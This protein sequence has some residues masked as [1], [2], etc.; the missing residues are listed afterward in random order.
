MKNILIALLF[1]FTT[2]VSLAQNSVNYQ[3][4]ECKDKIPLGLIESS[5]SK[6]KKDL[7]KLKELEQSRKER[8]L[9]SKFSLESHFVLDKLLQSGAVLFNDE[10]SNYLNQIAQKVLVNDSEELKSKVRVY[11][12]RSPYV[13]AFATE[14]GDIF[15]TLGLL[16][17]LQNEGQL[18]F[19]LAH[20]VSHVQ[21]KHSIKS[22]LETAKID[23]HFS[24]RSA[25][26]TSTE[27]KKLLRK[28]LYSKELE[29]E[30]DSLAVSRYL[31]AGYDKA[32]IMAVFEVLKK[33]EQPF[34]NKLFD[35]S[36]L[37]A[38]S[39]KIPKKY[40]DFEVTKLSK[41]DEFEEDN[42]S[43]HPNIG[44]RKE[45]VAKLLNRNM[46]ILQ[47]KGGAEFQK[48]AH[49]AQMELPM[50]YLHSGQASK[51]IYI[52]QVLLQSDPNNSFLKK[53][54]AKG[55]YSEAK[56]QN[57][58]DYSES[59]WNSEV[60][61]NIQRVYNFM[62]R[63]N[64]Q[65]TNALAMNYVWRQHMN[66]PD[67][68]ELEYLARDMTYELVRFQNGLFRFSQKDTAADNY[69]K[70]AMYDYK[71]NKKLL[72][73][74]ED[75]KKRYEEFKNRKPPKLSKR[76]ALGI[77]KI[78]VINPQY[79]QVDSRRGNDVR[80]VISEDGRYRI[81]DFVK[82]AA[83]KAKLD[84]EVLD[85]KSLSASQVQKFNDIRY[86]NEWFSEQA[87]FANLN[88]TPGYNQARIEEIAKR[89]DTKY[90]LWTGV[91]SAQQV[92]NS[93]IT[94]P[95]SVFFP[96]A[97]PFTTYSAIKPRY[98]MYY[99]SILYNVETGGYQLLGYDYFKRKDSDA[100]IK[101]HVYDS[102]HQIKRKKKKKNR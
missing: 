99:Y 52:A 94:V 75:S 83:K 82:L 14:R 62:G 86:L 23:R 20:E 32:D 71:D 58:D 64:D 49:I 56:F 76:T 9:L 3:L 90:F 67:D 25:R 100:L 28:S 5:T 40:K 57:D 89:Y 70:E 7:A 73:Y 26:K 81:T 36:E 69:W 42:E 84:C 17:R 66:Y 24:S 21:E 78:V 6:Y 18:A 96:P 34:S 29:L 11:T 72:G 8:K 60:E 59:K 44:T 61:G 95:I 1:V 12:L 68:S 19:V 41:I 77:D 93:W 74:F 39:Y 87:D 16:A 2:S 88:I 53:C 102:L 37:E 92:N 79:L 54:I 4:L 47:R 65:E 97:I 10:V 45:E 33:S 43:T 31:G 98:H 46:N 50:L 13:N 22:V 30:A 27:N 35:F 55:L 91:I 15:V 101:A 48:I 85:V 38:G 63:M 51:C 80:Y